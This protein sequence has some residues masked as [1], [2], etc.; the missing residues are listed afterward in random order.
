MNNSREF[1]LRVEP[2]D[3][4]KCM[5]LLFQLLYSSDRIPLAGS[6]WTT[7]WWTNFCFT[8]LFF[9][10]SLGLFKL[11]TTDL[12][13]ECSASSQTAYPLCSHSLNFSNSCIPDTEATLN[14]FLLYFSF[15]S[16]PNIITF[17]YSVILKL[18]S[19]WCNGCCFS[20]I[21]IV[22]YGNKEK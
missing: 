6:P 5:L 7:R 18:T 9:T 17:R 3:I 14:D 22:T 1:N 2:T 12:C 13:P 8:S 4:D 10:D 20:L 19:I 16:N 11:C 15:I 21:N